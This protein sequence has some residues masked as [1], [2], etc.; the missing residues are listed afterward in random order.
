VFVPGVAKLFPK[1]VKLLEQSGSGFFA[2]SGVTYVDFAVAEYLHF[3]RHHVPDVL[4][5]YPELSAFLD[6]VYALP[7]LKEYLA[8]RKDKHW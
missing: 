1:F 7:Q 3:V 8:V 6:R 5:K 2:P 4:D